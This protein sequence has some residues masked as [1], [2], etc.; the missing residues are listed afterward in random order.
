MLTPRPVHTRPP[1]TPQGLLYLR[2]GTALP[3]APLDR[4]GAI[5]VVL[6][7]LAFTP[8]YTVLVTFDHERKLLR[9]ETSTHM[10]S[11]CGRKAGAAVAACGCVRV[12]AVSLS[13]EACCVAATTLLHSLLYRP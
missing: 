9:R 6:I 12:E 8:S 7:M 11:R 3:N 5:F 10:Y 4:M 1:N 2:T 13:A